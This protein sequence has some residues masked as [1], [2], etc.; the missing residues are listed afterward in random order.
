MFNT[1]LVNKP[2][3]AY[4]PGFDPRKLSRKVTNYLLLGLAIPTIHDLYS[5]MPLEFLCCL[6]SLLSEF[7]SFQQL[8]GDSSSS[9][10][11]LTR[12]RLPN[13]SRRPG[14][15]YG[16]RRLPLQMWLWMM[17]LRFHTLHSPRRASQ[18]PLAMAVVTAALAKELHSYELCSLRTFATLCDVHID[19][20]TRILV[21]VPTP[22]ECSVS[23]T[24][25]FTKVDSKMRKIIVQGVV[26]D[27]EGHSRTHVKSEVAG[28]GKVVLGGLM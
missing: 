20:Y 15:K 8:H 17:P 18:L 16:G 24:E 21:P 23:I 14:V 1:Y 26:K 2:N 11:S 5:S 28:I 10:A 4:T 22:R 13:M 19:C 6:D 3:L 12:A 7:D 27:F 25:R 9:A